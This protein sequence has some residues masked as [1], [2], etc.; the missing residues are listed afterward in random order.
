[1]S[2]IEDGMGFSGLAPEPGEGPTT[3]RI[4]RNA[5]AE[6]ARLRLEVKEWRECAEYDPKMEGPRFKGWNRSR[7]DQCRTRFIEAKE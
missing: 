4:I 5:H 1:M 2:E 7:L 3:R 6:I